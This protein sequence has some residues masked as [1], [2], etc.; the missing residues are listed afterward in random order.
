MQLYKVRRRRWLRDLQKEQMLRKDSRMSQTLMLNKNAPHWSPSIKPKV[1]LSTSPFV[2]PSAHFSC[3]GHG[4][5]DHESWQW[6]IVGQLESRSLARFHC[7]YWRFKK[8]DLPEWIPSC[9]C[10]SW[11]FGSPKKGVW[12]WVGKEVKSHFGECIWYSWWLNSCNS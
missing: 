4:C 12:Q 6:W 7:L 9:N 1:H 2:P 8:N 3:R 11:I 10:P 5:I